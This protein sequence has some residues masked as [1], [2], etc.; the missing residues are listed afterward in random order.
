MLITLVACSDQDQAITKIEHFIKQQ[1]IDKSQ[2]S[3]KTQLAKPEL[4][5][6]STNKRYI[7]QLETSHGQLTLQLFP[8][9]A[10]MHVTS[11]I[12]LTQL[13]FYDDITFHRVIPQFMA[14]GGDPLGNGRGGPGYLYAGE[15]DLA[16]DNKDKNLA[17]HHKAG[18][19]SMANRGPNT[20]GSQFFITFNATPHLDGRHTVFGEVINDVDNVLATIEALGSRSGQTSETV[21]ILKASIIVEA[22]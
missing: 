7:W 8:D 12:Y 18:M 6:F 2:P 4:V 13:G 1:N 3:W 10:P 21:K 20:D 11:T 16:T 19:L 14:Q 15:F 17:K 5:N 9:V 22:L